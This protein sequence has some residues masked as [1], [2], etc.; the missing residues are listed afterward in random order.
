MKKRF[1]V[2]DKEGFTLIEIMVVMVLMSIL[3]SAA[4]ARIESLSNSAENK[5]IV[6]ALNE[7]NT[8]ETL[9]WTNI[10]ISD[11]EWISDDDV[12]AQVDTNFGSYYAWTTGPTASGGIL[13][14][15]NQSAALTRIA[16]T[17]SLAGI[18]KQA[19]KP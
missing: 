9:V 1:S 15:R 16:S 4:I 11:A 13:G 8:R 10:K 6:K 12:F 19:H 17:N 5:A 3:A 7:L 14:F 2:S 18:W